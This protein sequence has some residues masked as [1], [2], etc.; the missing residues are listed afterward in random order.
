MIKQILFSW[1]E[2]RLQLNEVGD[3][4]IPLMIAL[5]LFFVAFGF[6]EI[7]RWRFFQEEARKIARTHYYVDKEED[8]KSERIRN[9]V[10]WC[11]RNARKT[12]LVF[13]IS[14]LAILLLSF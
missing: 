2:F 12:F 4:A 11:F 8:W 14:A 13:M 10:N 6:Y 3:L 5:Y 7:D 1:T 9:L